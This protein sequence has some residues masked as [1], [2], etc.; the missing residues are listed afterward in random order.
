MRVL[1]T[2]GAGFIGSHIVDAVIARGERVAVLD[3][4]SSGRLENIDPRVN[5]YHGDTRDAGFVRETLR[6]ERPDFV[7]HQA[8][9]IDVQVSVDDPLTDAA[10]NI[11]G[12]LNLLEACR[13]YEVQKVVYASSAAVYGTPQYLPVD[14]KHPVNPLSGYGISKHTVEHYLAVY[15]A[16]YGL[17]YTALRYA[18]VYGPR[19]DATGEGGVVAI[20][21]S[22]LLRGRP[23][24]IFGDGMQT[25]DFVHV[26]DVA[27]ANL[28][29]LEA[30][31]EGIYNVSTGRP[32]TVNWLFETLRDIAGSDVEPLYEPPREG[33]IQHSYLDP[34]AAASGLGWRARTGLE[35]GLRQTV[36]FYRQWSERVIPG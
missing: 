11:M 14:E 3:N 17:N 8:A 30:G 32:T 25:R 36:D 35:D 18:N 31:D 28:A 26:H 10:V 13:T 24:R 5:L 1:V 34:G 20:F 19:Q 16:L 33:D 15:R 22:L 6:T 4:L 12:T 2:G 9:Q 7:I 21:A 29:A 23:P 27:R